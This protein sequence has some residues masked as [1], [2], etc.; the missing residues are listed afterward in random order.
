MSIP[1]GMGMHHLWRLWLLLLA[2]SFLPPAQRA[3]AEEGVIQGVVLGE[4][5][6]QLWPQ[7]CTPS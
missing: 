6:Q 7:R 5:G 4:G 2:I 3:E 1:G